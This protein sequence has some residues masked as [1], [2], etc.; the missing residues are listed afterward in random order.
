[1]E[2]KVQKGLSMAVKGYSNFLY[3]FIKVIS[4]HSNSIL[5]NVVGSIST[6]MG[7]TSDKKNIQSDYRKIGNDM[8]KAIG[9]YERT[10]L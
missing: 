1:M 8:R 7:T 5:D 2:N 6:T 3:G 4:V 10:E 9:E